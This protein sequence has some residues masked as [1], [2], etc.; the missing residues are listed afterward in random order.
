MDSSS[1]AVFVGWAE[2]LR[3]Q[4]TVSDMVLDEEGSVWTCGSFKKT[5]TF[6]DQVLDSRG[7]FDAFVVKVRIPFGIQRVSD[8]Q[9]P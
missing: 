7:S 8:K 1:E 3:G 5:V 9:Y 4:I 6:G 2:S